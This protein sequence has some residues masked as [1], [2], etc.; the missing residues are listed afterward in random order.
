VFY[1]GVP[2]SRAL[3]ERRLFDRERARPFVRVDVRVEKRFVLSPSAW[4]A[5]VAE[6]MNASLSSEV[7]RRPCDPDCRDDEVGPIVLPSL[8]V[9]GQF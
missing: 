2:G 3:G 6:V 7:V 5:V 4:W 8:G 9:L 1:S